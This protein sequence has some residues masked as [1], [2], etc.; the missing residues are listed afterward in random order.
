[1]LDVVPDE[2]CAGRAV[3]SHEGV[4]Y[5]GTAMDAELQQHVLGVATRCML[6]HAKRLRDL[7]VGLPVGEQHGH[8]GLTPRQSKRSSEVRRC[9]ELGRTV[10][11]GRQD[12]RRIACPSLQLAADVVPHAADTDVFATGAI[13]GRRADGWYRPQPA[14]R[15]SSP[16]A[17]SLSMR[18]RPRACSPGV[19]LKRLVQLWT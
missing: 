15:A 18:D 8:S 9:S 19:L 12:E 3:V 6:G 2:G 16:G 13:R 10:L 11:D 4:A 17:G 5:V 14:A 7:T 1:M